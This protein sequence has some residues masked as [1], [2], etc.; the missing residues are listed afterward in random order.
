MSLTGKSTHIFSTNDTDTVRRVS[1]PEIVLQL[2][3]AG[4]TLSAARRPLLSAWRPLSLTGTQ[5]QLLHLMLQLLH[6]RLQQL[7]RLSQPERVR[8]NESDRYAQMYGCS[9]GRSS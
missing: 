6:L 3:Q 9:K 8:L 4:H 5:L 7:H 2:F 1:L